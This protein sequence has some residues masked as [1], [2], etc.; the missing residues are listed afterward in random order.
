MGFIFLAE[1]LVL[2]HKGH[3]DSCGKSNIRRNK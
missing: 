1:V 2:K 3:K